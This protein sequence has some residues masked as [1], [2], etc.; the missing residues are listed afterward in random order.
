MSSGWRV[1]LEASA[2]AGLAA[3]SMLNAYVISAVSEAGRDLLTQDNVNV[4]LNRRMA[5]EARTFRR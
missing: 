3:A 5:T 2:V 1:L 4:A